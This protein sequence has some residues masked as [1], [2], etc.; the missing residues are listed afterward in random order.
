[1]KSRVNLNRIVLI[2]IIA[3]AAVCLV[4]SPAEAQKKKKKK[5][6]KSQ[7]VLFFEAS[8]ETKYDDNIINYSDDDL[9]LYDIN[10]RPDK[11]AIESKDDWIIIPRIEGRIKGNFIG[12]HTGWFEVNFTDY[13]YARNEVRRFQRYGASA[14]QYFM[15]GAYGEVEYYYIPD[16]YYRNQYYQ[17]TGSYIEASFAKHFLKLEAGYDIRSNLKADLSYRYQRKSFNSEVSERNL[18]IHQ[19][20]FDA[21][22]RATRVQKIWVY[23]DLERA[24]AAGKDD[25]NPEARDVSYDAWDITLGTRLYSRLFGKLRPE[26]VSHLQ[27]REIK[28]Q[29]VKYQDIYRFGRK[30]R[31]IVFV[32]G[33]SWNLPYRLRF[34]VDYTYKQKRTDLPVPSV[35]SLL[36][37]N[38]NI[39]SFELNRGF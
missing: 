22:W 9:D 34:N 17:A 1:M 39:V 20:R 33:T 31:N 26:V 13:H 19:A 10:A 27:F 24:V 15:K 37:Y 11:F 32:V 18:N 5:K 4:W 2:T 30:D 12:G 21:V 6:P 14:R 38:S 29:T 23:Y 16:Y 8:L 7:Q 28:F 3:F 35:E 36:D 25:P